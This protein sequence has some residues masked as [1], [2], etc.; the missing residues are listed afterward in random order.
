MIQAILATIGTIA[1]G[2]FGFKKKQGE[3]IEKGLSVLNDVNATS[4]ARSAA[5]AQIITSEAN[6]ESWIT[7][8]WRPI[9]V[10]LLVVDLHILIY[11]LATGQFPVALL[12]EM[13]PIVESLINII[14][15]YLI[16]YGASR[17]IEKITRGLSIGSLLKKFI[18]KKLL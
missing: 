16:G 14:G 11:L 4:Q 1:T 2:I 10:V 6:S 13:P 5:M 3:V 9:V 17:S 18:E 7:R 12:T 8:N 15:M